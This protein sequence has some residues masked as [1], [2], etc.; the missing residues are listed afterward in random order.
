MI[1]FHPVNLQAD[2]CH[3]GII[4]E[5]LSELDPRSAKDQFNANYSHGGGWSP[6]DGFKMMA[7]GIMSY[8]G[9][10]PFMPLYIAH[11]RTET[12]FVYESA[13]VAIVQPNGDFEVARL[14]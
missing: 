2:Q 11:L 8:D 1:Q 13:W 14:D 3:L 10:P 5:F 7:G 6:M 12:I 4:P 9:D